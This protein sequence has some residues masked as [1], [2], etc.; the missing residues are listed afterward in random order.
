MEE[1]KGEVHVGVG[2]KNP[3][4]TSPFVPTKN[5]Q[6]TLVTIITPNESMNSG[7]HI[8]LSLSFSPSSSLSFSCHS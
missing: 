5:K 6:Y 3:T 8:S 7:R 4:P 2:S 1:K